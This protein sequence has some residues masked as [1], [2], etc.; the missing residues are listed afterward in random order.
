MRIPVS[1]NNLEEL[2]G[3]QASPFSIFHHRD[4]FR[5]IHSWLRGIPTISIILDYC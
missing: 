5:T 4:H 2:Y 3:A 1:S